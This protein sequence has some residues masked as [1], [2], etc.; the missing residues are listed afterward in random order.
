MLPIWIVS[1]AVLLPLNSIKSRVGNN[2]GLE[3]FTF[4]NVQPDQRIRYVGH[5]ILVWFF[6][7]A[8]NQP[9]SLLPLRDLIPPGW[10]FYNIRKEMRHFVITRQH[11]LIDSNHS[12]TIQAN[13][14]LVTGIP[15]KYLNQKSLQK[16]YGSLPGGVKKIWVNR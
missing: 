13:T 5:L 1:W 12:K 2:S 7:G 16:V 9:L 8:F 4:G 14:I 10:I 3:L 15:V 6:T 11:H